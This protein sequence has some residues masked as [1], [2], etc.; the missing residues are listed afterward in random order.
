VTSAWA[1]NPD[2]YPALTTTERDFLQASE[3]ANSRR[4]RLRRTALAALLILL[5]AS[6]TGAGLAITAAGNANYQRK[7]SVSDEL[8]A[9][10]EQLDTADPVT[11]SQLA[12]ASWEVLPTEQARVSMLDVLAQKGIATID[13]DTDPNHPAWWRKR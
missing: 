5:V 8:A 7:Y 6:I 1:A 10:S 3:R 2:R 11:A 4:I 9:E 13:A 12:A